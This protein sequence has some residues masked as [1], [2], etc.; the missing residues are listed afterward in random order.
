MRSAIRGRRVRILGIVILVP[1]LAVFGSGIYLASLSGA[2]PWQTDPTRI[3]EGF[4]PF[5][6]IE[7]FETPTQIPTRAASPPAATPSAGT[8][9][10][11]ATT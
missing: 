3:S 7:G 4:A 5:S 1:V 11:T 6:G 8:P 10:S 2:L 9:T